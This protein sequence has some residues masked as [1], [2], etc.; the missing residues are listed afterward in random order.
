[1]RVEVPVRM[2]VPVAMLVTGRVAVRVHVA[3]LMPVLVAVVRHVARPVPLERARVGPAP[4]ARR[5]RHKAIL[6]PARRR[7]RRSGT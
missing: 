6:L 5:I 2:A 7:P 4:A 3:V 1:V